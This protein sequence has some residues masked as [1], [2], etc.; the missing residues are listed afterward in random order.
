MH[1][2]GPKNKM[3]KPKTPVPANALDDAALDELAK[4]LADQFGRTAVIA[5]VDGTEQLVKPRAGR[6]LD[7]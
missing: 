1:P 6:K 3:P 5:K 4:A 7:S 2:W